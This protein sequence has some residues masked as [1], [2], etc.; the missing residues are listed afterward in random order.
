[1]VKS[2]IN[3]AT[4]YNITLKINKRKKKMVVIYKNIIKILNYKII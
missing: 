1:M 3:Y 4:K 2:L